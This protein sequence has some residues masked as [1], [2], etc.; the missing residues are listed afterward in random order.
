MKKNYLKIL[1]MFFMV[2][3]LSFSENSN[4]I[5]VALGYKGRSYDPHKHTDSSTLA[6]TKQIYNNLFYLDK[7]GNIQNELADSYKIDKHGNI[8][9]ILKKGIKFH[10][11]DLLTADVVINSLKNNLSTP[12]TKVLA[13]PIKDIIKIDDMT[14]KI[15]Q[16]F[17]PQIV[18]HNLTHSSLAITK[19]NNDKNS[20]IKLLGT[21]PFK[22]EYW[23]IGENV[24]L[25]A[26][27]DYY[28]GKPS[29]DK[30]TFV[31]IPETSNRFIALE[32]GEI[33][34]AYDIAAID[35]QAFSKDKNLKL[36]SEIS[37]GTDFLSINTNKEP[38]NNT[39]LRK[40][41]ACALDKEAVNEV[42]FEGSSKIA[43]SILTPK[44]FGYDPNLK[45]RTKNIEEGKRLV[46]EYGKPV[47]IDLWIYEDPAKY[48]MAQVIQANLKE[49]GI[50]VNIETLELS[51]FLQFSAEGKHNSLIGLWYASTG[52]ADYGFYP[53]LHSS[54]K[55]AVGNRSF[56]ENKEVDNLL[57]EARKSSDPI[58]RKEKYKKVQEIVSEDNPIIPIVYKMYNIGM[59]KNIEGFEFLPSGNHKLE[60]IRII[61]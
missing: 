33:D 49:I 24:K 11:G 22:L 21:G 15:E 47:S 37:Y 61:K 50:D 10:D 46:K 5:K 55:G 6:V 14:I 44:T 51:S 32:T 18:L 16:N 56:Y 9:V 30:V 59:Q 23:G 53:L 19:E 31:T 17:N 34:I 58:V 3:I 48:Q 13:E 45:I 40:A 2:C 28:K 8:I 43:N 39:N 7:D 42:V 38:L 27:D 41:I 4:E 36:I 54:S 1:G 57:E 25:S 20:E 12:V 29:L 26:F 52:D 35:V 60:N